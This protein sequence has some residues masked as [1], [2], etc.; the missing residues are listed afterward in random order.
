MNKILI[1]G[2]AAMCLFGVTACGGSKD[3]DDDKDDAGVVVVDG[4]TDAGVE[5]AGVEDAGVQDAGVEDGGVNDPCAACGPD[6]ICKDGKECADS[7]YGDDCTQATFTERCDGNVAVYCSSRGVTPLYCDNIWGEGVSKCSDVEDWG[8]DCVIP[9]DEEDSGE[10]I[11]KCTVMGD[12]VGAM[13][14]VKCAPLVAGGFGAY[15]DEDPAACSSGA[16]ADDGLTCQKLHPDEGNTCVAADYPDRCAGNVVAWCQDGKVLASDCGDTDHYE[17]GS[18]C[19]FASVYG[20][21]F[22]FGP[23]MVCELPDATH[24]DTEVFCDA[25]EDQSGDLFTAVT[26][27]ICAATDT[28][29]TGVW[30]LDEDVD[31]EVCDPDETCM[32]G[33]GDACVAIDSSVGT[34]CNP[35]SDTVVCSSN[36]VAILKCD[37]TSS[38]WVVDTQCV[39]YDRVCKVFEGEAD[40]YEDLP[41]T[42]VEAIKNE[43]VAFEI[44][45]MVMYSVDEFQC[46][47]AD[48][49]SKLWVATGEYEMCDDTCQPGASVC[50]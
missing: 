26:Q 13:V 8:V 4:G 22:C 18:V 38:T 32:I 44:W 29:G 28:A 40:C 48:D 5:D 25:D 20:G 37:S 46:S 41:C 24:P 39:V 7:D 17:E 19:L 23:D 42:E 30:A 35:A 12:D 9:C 31:P 45:G 14:T 33:D 1:T 6:Q 49:G 50:D 2:I 47:Q 3:K 15:L 11:T 43:C 34:A 16:C 27:R 36:G 21:A 10:K